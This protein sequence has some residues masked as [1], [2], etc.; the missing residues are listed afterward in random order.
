[1]KTQLSYK[2]SCTKFKP[3]SRS[4]KSRGRI[5]RLLLAALIGG[6]SLWSTSSPSVAAELPFDKR[7][8]ISILVHEFHPTPTTSDAVEPI[9]PAD[10][11]SVETK[12]NADASNIVAAVGTHDSVPVVIANETLSTPTAHRTSSQFNE[13]IAAAVSATAAK[14]GISVEQFL[15]PFAMVGPL[16]SKPLATTPL[17]EKPAN[18]AEA[19]T[20][21]PVDAVEESAIAVTTKPA[22]PIADEPVQSVLTESVPSAQQLAEAVALNRWWQ[23]E[24]IDETDNEILNEIVQTE[25]ETSIV[26]N[27]VE[28][29]VENIAED[30]VENT[31]ESVVEEE[32]TDLADALVAND[33]EDKF[34][35][36]APVIVTIQEAYSPYDIAKRD[37]E[38]EYLDLTTVQPIHP[39]N[40]VSLPADDALALEDADT[41]EIAKEFES[42]ELETE[43]AVAKTEDGT[44]AEI[45]VAQVDNNA[46]ADDIE[47]VVA[48][49]PDC[50]LD[51]WIHTAS[52]WTENV[53]TTDV[54]VTAVGESVGTWFANFAIPA[55]ANVAEEVP[56]M[57]VANET[58]PAPVPDAVPNAA[59]EPE[60]VVEMV[61]TDA[62]DAP[63]EDIAAVSDEPI[64]DEAVA[65]V[66]A[67][68]PSDPSDS[69]EIVMMDVDGEKIPAPVADEAP[70]AVTE[71][72]FAVE[73]SVAPASDALAADE[74]VMMDINGEKVP[75]PV[76]DDVPNATPEEAL[77]VEDNEHPSSDDVAVAEIVSVETAEDLQ[78]SDAADALEVVEIAEVAPKTD[79][80]EQIAVSDSPEQQ[81]ENET[82]DSD[83]NDSES[84]QQAMSLSAIVAA[85]NQWQ[86]RT[87]AQILADIEPKEEPTALVELADA[88]DVTEPTDAD[89]SVDAIESAEQV[90]DAEIEIANASE[91]SEETIIR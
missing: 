62:K 69:Q 76:A 55:E 10:T 89:E 72:S 24:T 14:V 71:E 61:A 30:I 42:E 78:E 52:I 67:A 16:A 21:I 18:D 43:D 17:A 70:N 77:A 25:I 45:E 37:L 57:I 23:D 3:S 48:V 32:S 73:E 81:G 68:E 29:A 49:S 36:S 75:A 9:A 74:I 7:G 59:P 28:N 19:T 65:E 15:E 85:I 31:V 11:A 87:I 84:F 66:A 47:E 2:R 4:P 50:L 39:K 56:M 34:V 6:A 26:E 5:R 83:Q 13:M 33:L 79:T 54:S 40:Y 22:N 27:V 86:N 53:R 51:E 80:L 60:A 12:P 64:S 41:V 38:M 46:A 35:G 91:V 8:G 88:S 58:I 1:M 44:A 82:V 63:A 90:D 20:E